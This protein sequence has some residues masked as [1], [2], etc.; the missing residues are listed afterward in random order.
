MYIKSGNATAYGGGREINTTGVPAAAARLPATA[1]AAG[2][3]AAAAARIPAAAARVPAATA[4]V[5][6]ATAARGYTDAP[7]SAISGCLFPAT[8]RGFCLQTSLYCEYSGA[9][10]LW[11]DVFLKN[12]FVTLSEDD[13]ASS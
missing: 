4:R 5:P 3:P 11:Q 9:H 8:T 7:D 13:M 2:I 10:V 12:A 1:A 6:A